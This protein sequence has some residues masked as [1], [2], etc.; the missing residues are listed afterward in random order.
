MNNLMIF[1][2]NNVEVFDYEGRILFNPKH[3]AECLEIVDVNSSIRSFNEKQ[4][5]KLSNSNMHDMHFRKLHNTGE[6]FLTES[7]VYKLIFKSKK[8]N[9]EEF[10]DWVTDE[11][12]PTIRKTGG[13]VNDDQMFINTY[14]PYADDV[15]KTLFSQI[16]HTVRDNN[17][18]IEEQNKMI[19]QKDTIIDNVISDG[20]IYAVGTVGKILKSYTNNKMGAKNIFTYLKKKSI[21]MDKVGTQNN[22]LPYDKYAR[23]FNIKYTDLEL[24]GFNKTISKLYFNTK[25]LKWFLHK[26]VE[27]EV[28]TTQQQDKAMQELQ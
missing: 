3:V 10:Q 4:V 25:G 7:G 14:L 18:K 11:V 19:T 2:G 8:E 22:N 23:Y 15:T 20:N 12:L 28:M 26:L 6:N 9:A 5:I 16:M 17:K 1:E 13:Y 27:D 24:G 21:I